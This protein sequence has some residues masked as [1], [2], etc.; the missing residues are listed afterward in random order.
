MEPDK[1]SVSRK[2]ETDKFSQ[3]NLNVS[4]TTSKASLKADKLIAKAK[5]DLD[6]FFNEAEAAMGVKSNFDAFIQACKYSTSHQ[7]E[8]DNKAFAEMLEVQTSQNSIFASAGKYNKIFNIYFKLSPKQKVILE[9]YYEARQFNSDLAKSF[10]PGIGLIPF[11]KTGQTFSKMLLRSSGE[12][13]TREFKKNLLKLQREVETL[14]NDAL[15][16][17]IK[18]SEEK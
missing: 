15:F 8:V 13:F 1:N 2:L 17:F 10:G 9:A 14:Y 5:K 6:W 3:D 4:K 18:A 16:A 11:T 12:V 7:D